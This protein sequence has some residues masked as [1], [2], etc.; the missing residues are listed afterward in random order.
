MGINTNS[1]KGTFDI[2]DNPDNA[3]T[4]PEGLLIPRLTTSEINAMVVGADQN[5]LL[6]YDTDEECVKLYKHSEAT[7][8]C[9]LDSGSDTV[10]LEWRYRETDTGAIGAAV[11]LS[12]VPIIENIRAADAGNPYMIDEKGN[13]ILSKGNVAPLV[14]DAFAEFET[15]IAGFPLNEKDMF[16]LIGNGD[17]DITMAMGITDNPNQAISLHGIRIEADL[18]DASSLTNVGNVPSG[19]SLL[20]LESLTAATNGFFGNVKASSRILMST[21]GS[22]SY[23]SRPG[24]ISFQ[25]TAENSTVPVERLSIDKNG[26]III[27][28]ASL[29]Q[30]S[31]SLP[32]GTICLE[33]I[34]TVEVLSVKR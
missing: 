8:L 28:T 16:T 26:N 31:E 34:G 2:V 9:N 24:K 1:P 15:E 33:T 5:G 6:V 17:S 4:D 19:A 23:T 18:S 21:D 25:T 12:S 11:G 3:N 22:H 10:D 14:L 27:S 29:K 32:T 30:C 7:W 13:H 20:N